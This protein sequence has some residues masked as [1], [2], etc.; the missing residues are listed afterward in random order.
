VFL[1]FEKRLWGPL[2]PCLAAAALLIVSPAAYA[3][4]P[5]QPAPA[6]TKAPAATPAAPVAVEPSAS[7]LATARQLVVVSGMSRSFDAAIPQM[8]N[9]L[10]TAIAQTRPKIAPDLAV[11]L[12]QL[13]PEFASDVDRMID[14]AA[15]I[16]AGLL[17]ETELKAAVAFFSSD[18]GKKYVH[19]EPIFFN[20]VINAMQDWHDQISTKMMARVRAEMKKK[21]HVL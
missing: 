6:A 14:R 1:K 5:N 12:K 13:Q 8:L 2:A 16:Y 4:K 19:A 3:Q 10:T 15:H 9:R 21:G 7:Q 17:S 20:K 11:V 18:A